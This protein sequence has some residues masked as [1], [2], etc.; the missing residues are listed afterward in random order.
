MKTSHELRVEFNKEI[1]L[2]KKTQTE[3]NLEIK[4]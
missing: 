1:Q 3:K 2:L 4:N